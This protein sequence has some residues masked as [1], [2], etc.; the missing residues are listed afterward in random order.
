MNYTENTRCISGENTPLR[1][2]KHVYFPCNSRVCVGRDATLLPVNLHR[3]NNAN[4]S[5]CFQDDNLRNYDLLFSILNIFLCLKHVSALW[6]HMKNI[7]IF[8]H[9]RRTHPQRIYVSP[10]RRRI[11]GIY[12]CLLMA[13][14]PIAKQ[15]Q[16]VRRRCISIFSIHVFH[17]VACLNYMFQ[18]WED[19]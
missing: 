12:T 8:V 16:P 10:L 6:R 5:Q 15:W 18:R 3:L 19:T 4:S 14:S 13:N 11:K 9:S 17:A 1:H 2:Q 7:Y